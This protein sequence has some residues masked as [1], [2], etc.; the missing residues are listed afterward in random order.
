MLK[1]INR[2]KIADFGNFFDV[3]R[4]ASLFVTC[5]IFQKGY[6]IFMKQHFGETDE[7]QPVKNLQTVRCWEL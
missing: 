3:T 2:E 1:K 6:H 4:G 7:L 5:V